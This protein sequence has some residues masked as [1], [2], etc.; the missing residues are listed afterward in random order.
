M[1]AEDADYLVK[2][3]FG[4]LRLNRD[5]NQQKIERVRRLQLQA[6]FAGLR[7]VCESRKIREHMSNISQLKYAREWLALSFTSP[8]G[9]NEY[10]IPHCMELSRRPK[11]STFF[12]QANQDLSLH[13]KHQVFKVLHTH[14]N[15]VPSFLSK[16]N[17]ILQIQ[18]FE[19][20]K[21]YCKQRKLEKSILM[22]T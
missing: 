6:R 21:R 22:N 5:R 1:M 9:G 12:H 7:S 18:V 4:R 11:Y 2:W 14:K 3:C 13:I 16:T 17:K 19:Q 20:M 10:P 8:D 15:R